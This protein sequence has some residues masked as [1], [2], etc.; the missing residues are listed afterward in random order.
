MLHL[1]VL[2]VAPHQVR[3]GR[4]LNRV[5]P[6]QSPRTVCQHRW[7]LHLSV[8]GGLLWQRTHLSAQESATVQ[9]CHVLQLQTLQKDQ[10]GSDKRR[11]AALEDA[12][13]V[14]A[15][16]ENLLAFSLRLFLFS[17]P[18]QLV[19]KKKQ[20]NKTSSPWQHWVVRLTSVEG[21]LCITNVWASAL[22]A[23]WTVMTGGFPSSW[24]PQCQRRSTLRDSLL[25]QQLLHTTEIG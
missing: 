24:H 22:R 20:K 4:M 13:S 8:F 3:S 25:Q 16:L 7:F 14:P 6:V 17:F 9:G 5:S 19:K 1:F 23:K 18:S 21:T 11:P 10:N 2:F 15:H 12:G